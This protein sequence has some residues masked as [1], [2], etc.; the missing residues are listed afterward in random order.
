MNIKDYIWEQF[1]FVVAYDYEYSQTPGNNP[2]PVC[3]TYKDLKTG[4]ITQQWLLGRKQKSPFPVASTLFI[5]HYAVAEVSCDI[6][7]GITKPT[8]IFD[9]FVEEKKM[10]NGK[11]KVGF[12]LLDTCE[13]YNIKGV[14]SEAHK[15]LWRDTI[16]NNFPNYSDEEQQGILKYNLEDVLT[17]EKLFY[18]QLEKL[19]FKNNN[20]HQIVS[21]ACFHGRSM[22]VCAQIEHNGI[23]VNLEIYNDL[24]KHYEEVKKLEIDS[25]TKVFDCYD[26]DKFSNKKFATAIEKEGLLERWPKTEKGRLKTDDRTI[27]RFAEVS[28]AIQQYRASKFII[29]SRKLKGYEIG[30]D[31]RSRTS[32]NMFGQS[33]GRTNVSTATNPFG[34]P[35]RMRT[36]IGTT[37]DKILVYADFKSQEAVIQA[38]LSQDQNM[39]AAVKSGDPYLH[40][41]KLVGAIPQDA[42][43]KSHEK[44]REIYKQS[45]LAISYGQTP[46]GLKNKLGVPIANATYIHA[47][48][49]K[50]YSD[51]QIW[52]QSLKDFAM[53]R[54]YL[55]TKYGWR[56]WLSDRELVNPRQLGNWPIQSHGSEILRR[57]M[58]ELDDAG[59]EISMIIHDAILIHM[60]RK[61]CRIKIEALKKIM[62]AA[63]YEVIGSEIEVDSQLIKETY[64]QKGEHKEMWDN[65][66]EKLLKV[67]KG[68]VR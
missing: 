17:N 20:Y 10:L 67:K 50:A 49:I 68:G 55:I 33:T 43:R 42:T 60:D 45:F 2:D 23:P 18:A 56:Y 14:M 35:R 54:G 53:R 58:I 6:V 36:M 12:G 13:R 59:F 38:Q 4:K 41:A 29:E 51:Y 30:K 48:I 21:Q 63:A 5:C 57:A 40:T 61:D 32:L 11:I 39:I 3:V 7:R 52:I 16:I 62:S 37:K 44:I 34:A 19:S 65:L 47:A 8:F 15:T 31:G 27:Y 24:D 28:P 1:D 25:L 26:G 22:G 66:Y 46:F 64:Q 9:S